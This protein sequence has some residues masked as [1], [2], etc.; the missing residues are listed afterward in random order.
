MQVITVL[1]NKDYMKE[2]YKNNRNSF[3]CII[4][5]TFFSNLTPVVIFLPDSMT[6]ESTS[7]LLLKIFYT[8]IVLYQ[9]FPRMEFI[10]Q[11]TNTFLSR[12]H[13]HSGF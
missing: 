8:L 3:F 12:F 6:Q 1:I 4:F 7:I 2:S 10:F 9:P 11:T 5:F 13:L